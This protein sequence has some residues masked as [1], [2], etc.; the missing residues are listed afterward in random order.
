MEGAVKNENF[1]E[2]PGLSTPAKQFF[3]FFFAPQTGTPSQL[4]MVVPGKLIKNLLLSHIIV[5]GLKSY[6]SIL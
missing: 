3:P 4:L 2:L 1:K 6:Y 5:R